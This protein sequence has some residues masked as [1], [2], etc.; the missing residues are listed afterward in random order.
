MCWKCEKKCIFYVK[1]RNNFYC[2]VIKK[3]GTE[4]SNFLLFVNKA[5]TFKICFPNF[6]YTNIAKRNWN[7]TF[8]GG[9][10]LTQF[11]HSLSTY[12]GYINAYKT[13]LIF[14]FHFL[15]IWSKVF[16]SKYWM[17]WFY[18]YC[19]HVF[20]YWTDHSV[21]RYLCWS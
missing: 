13:R 15:Y 5:T 2:C 20:K 10:Y 7:Y 8:L 14:F 9:K 1:K 16:F 17:S 18:L 6:D 21:T 4:A 19:A 3:G 12:Y 11:S